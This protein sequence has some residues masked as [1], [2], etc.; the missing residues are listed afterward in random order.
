MRTVGWSIGFIVMDMT[1][2]GQAMTIENLIA[3]K[4]PNPGVVFASL[5]VFSI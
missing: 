3:D 5:R 4:P 1:L 2:V